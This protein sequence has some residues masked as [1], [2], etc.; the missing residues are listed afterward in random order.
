MPASYAVADA[1]IAAD[2]SQSIVV[3][4]PFGMRGGIPVYGAPFFPKALV[5]A[6][7]DGHP[8]AIAYTSRMPQSTISAMAAH[9]FYA[10][11]IYIQHQVPMVCPWAVPSVRPTDRS[12]QAEATGCPQPPGVV[13]LDASKLSPTQLAEARLDAQRLHI[14]WAVV[15]KRNISVAGFVLPYLKGTGFKYAYRDGNVLVYRR[16]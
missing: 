1:G 6:T 12:H 7:A 16:R 15:W 5:M 3:D 10:D 8:R 14:G 2:H 13:P 9:P 4:L 11:L